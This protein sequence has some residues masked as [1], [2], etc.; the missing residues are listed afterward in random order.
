[1][2]LVVVF[3]SDGKRSEEI[4]MRVGKTNTVLREVLHRSAITKGSL[5]TPYNLQ[6]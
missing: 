4:D 6:L 1:M 3:T 2:Y 5:Q